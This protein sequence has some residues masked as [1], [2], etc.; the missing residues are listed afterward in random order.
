MGMIREI[1]ATL[2]E[3]FFWVLGGVPLM[4]TLWFLPYVVV[5]ALIMV[6]PFYFAITHGKNR[7]NSL[8][9]IVFLVSFFPILLIGIGP[10]IIQ[11]QMLQECETVQQ[12]VSTD[13]VDKHVIDIRQCRLKDNYYGEFGDWKIYRGDR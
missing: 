8:P 5:L 3:F 6:I 4:N 7:T 2:S 13:K 10:P 12:V 9:S 11:V 1:M